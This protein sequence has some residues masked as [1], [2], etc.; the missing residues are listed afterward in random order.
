[1]GLD[2]WSLGGR[3]FVCMRD[4]FILNEVWTQDK[5]T[6]FGRHFAW[7]G[8]FYLLTNTGTGSEL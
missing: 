6:Y 5:N 3:E 4:I 2:F 7:F 1:M 8:I